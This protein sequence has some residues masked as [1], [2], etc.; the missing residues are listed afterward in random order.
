MPIYELLC[1][2]NYLPKQNLVIVGDFVHGLYAGYVL[3][4]PP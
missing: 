3:L 2:L 4:I 1:S